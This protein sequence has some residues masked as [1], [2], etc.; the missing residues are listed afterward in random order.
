MTQTQKKTL[1]LAIASLILGCFFWIPLLGFLLGMT[2]LIMGIVALVKINKN[3][4]QL[5]GEGLAIAGIV[6][7]GLSLLVIPVLALLAAIAIPNMLRARLNAN[8]AMAQANI[9]ALA[10]AME[11]YKTANDVYPAGE[12]ELLREQYIAHAYNGQTVGGYGFAVR[13]SGTAYEI[14]AVP[15]A[16]GTTGMTIFRAGP[17]VEI[18]QTPCGSGTSGDPAGS[19]RGAI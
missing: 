5:Q 10:T 3:K 16:C 6:M 19:R 15:E 11:S 12:D 14:I 17:N 4:E 18:T 9:R 2:A 1:G 7:G 8:E 13:S